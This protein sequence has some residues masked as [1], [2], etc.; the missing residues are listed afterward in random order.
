[1]AIDL[2]TQL[3][4]TQKRLM[5]ALKNARFLHDSCY[6]LN[7]MDNKILFRINWQLVNQGCHVAP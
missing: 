4:T 1:M 3:T 2:N 7:D 6:C 5:C